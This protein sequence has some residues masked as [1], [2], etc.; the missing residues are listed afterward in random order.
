[1]PILKLQLPGSLILASLMLKTGAY[2][3]MR[4]VIPLFPNASAT[5]APVGMILGV[6]GILY[7]AKLAFAQ[8]DLKRL[9]A[10]TSVSHMGFIIFGLYLHLMKWLTREL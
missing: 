10:Y 9:V 2:G 3:L 7:G 1:M 5:F 4:F 8:T 6:V